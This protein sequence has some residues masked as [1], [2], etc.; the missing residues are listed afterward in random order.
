MPRRS[1]EY[2]DRQRLRFCEAAMACF[3]RKGVVATS[4]TDIC[5]ETGLT[6]GALYKLFNSRDDLLEATLQFLLTRRNNRLRGDTWDDLKI[7][8]L[9]YRDELEHNPFWRELQGVA[10]WNERLRTLRVREATYI[11]S[12]IEQQLETYTAN[13]EIRPPFDLRRTAH[14]I[15]VIFDGSLTEVRTDEA[16]RVDQE[17]FG[18]YLDLAVGFTGLKPH[19]R[20]PHLASVGSE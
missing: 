4:L 2:M 6:M 18:T 17:D 3:R 14:L 16:L 19:P 1:L 8:L 20:A 11:L 15:S 7:A 9:T 5:N 10:D 13:R 12:Q